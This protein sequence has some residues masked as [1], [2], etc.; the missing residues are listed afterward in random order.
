MVNFKGITRVGWAG[1]GA[2]GALVLLAA[3]TATVPVA[4]GQ[5]DD[6][7]YDEE[8]TVSFLESKARSL[9]AEGAVDTVRTNVWLTEAL[10]AEIVSRTA[11]VLPPTPAALRLINTA[12]SGSGDA[13]EQLMFN[14]AMVRV[15]G[16]LGYTLF[17][18]GEDDFRQA[19][20]DY[21]IQYQVVSVDLEYPDVGRTLG[22]WRQW[23]A[24][25]LSVTAQVE[26][27]EADS[28]RVLLSDRITRSFSDRVPDGDLEHVDSPIYEFSTAEVG[29]SGWKKRL[30][31][32]VV[33]GTLAGLVAVYFANTT[34]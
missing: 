34:D 26:V 12:S 25:E 1:R 15:L 21:L 10:L 28:G 11:R 27:L 20:V 7:G 16:G 31:E 33:L 14:E 9:P 17:M 2:L 8:P 18:A 13:D 23:I 4:L 32:M 29:E 6:A 19:A 5:G 24:R 22:I 3:L 30:E